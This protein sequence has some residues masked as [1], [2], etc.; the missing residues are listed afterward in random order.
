MSVDAEDLAKQIKSLDDQIRQLEAE[1][2]RRKEELKTIRTNDH[3]EYCEQVLSSNADWMVDSLV[4]EHSYSGHTDEEYSKHDT[5]CVRCAL[6]RTK[7]EHWW[8]T[9]YIIRF[10]LERFE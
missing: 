7:K 3:N 10:R 6:L 5:K 9:D 4:K 1:R 2:D 8:D